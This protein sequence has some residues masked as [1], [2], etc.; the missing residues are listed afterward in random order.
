MP[1]ILQETPGSI[2]IVDDDRRMRESLK[3][4]LTIYNMDSTL[5]ENGQQALEYLT[6]NHFDLVLLD[7][8]MPKK[9]GFQVMKAIHDLYPGTDVII[10]SGKA[11]FGNAQKAFRLGAKDFLNKPYSP[12][13]LIKIIQKISEKKY[14]KKK[15]TDHLMNRH[16]LTGVEKTLSELENIIHS[17]ALTFTNKIINSSPA[18]AFLWKNSP[19]WPVQFVS[20]NVT[21]LLGYTANEFIT[22]KVIYKDIIHPDDVDQVIKEVS[23]DSKTIKFKHKPYRVITKFGVVKW[24]DDSSSVVVDEQGNITHFQG[25]I[26]DV[27][28]REL[29]RQ[30]MLQNQISLQHVAYHDALTGLPNRLLLLDRMLQTKK[31]AL[32]ANK[33]WAVLYIDLDKFKPINDTL[34][35]DAG[36][37]VLKIVANRL[38]ESVRAVDTVARIGGD[39]F[40]VLMEDISDVQD[41]KI[42]AQKLN[43][44][45]S[46]PIYWEKH[47]LIITP[48]IGISLSLDDNMDIGLDAKSMVEEHIKRADRAMYQSKVSGGNTFQLYQHNG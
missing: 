21:H 42:M 10:L 45:L 24:V 3:D 35:H 23:K 15:K 13:E 44:S 8:E 22:E 6:D 20:E 19:H 39:E 5:A 12:S 48:S 1:P 9:N 31:K 14:L 25:I 41:V 27:T 32:R 47:E 11:S 17:E 29:A 34:G 4:L 40:I 18:V 33:N 46:Y 16:T 37:E 30:K 28:K 26:I 2:L 43:E 7:I 36:D 38:S